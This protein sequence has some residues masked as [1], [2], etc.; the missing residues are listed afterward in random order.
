MNVIIPLCGKGERFARRGYTTQKPFIKVGGKELIRHTLDSL[1]LTADDT[2]YVVINKRLDDC[3]LGGFLK[4][5]YHNVNVLVLDS[6]TRGAAETALRAVERIKNDQPCLLVDGDNFYTINICE[7]LR[8]APTENAVVVFEQLEGPLVFSYVRVEMDRIVEI[9][10]KRKISNYANTGAYYFRSATLLR[11]ACA[12]ALE[13]VTGEPYISHAIGTILG[14]ENWKPIVISRSN[15]YSLGTP[16]Q[17][18]AF[19][20]RTYAFLFDLDGTL[21]H[22]DAAYYKVWETLLA[23]YN[24][25]LTKEIYDTYIF[26]NSDYSVKT[27]LLSSAPISLE[28]LT[29]RKEALFLSHISDITVVKGALEFINSLKAEAHQIAVVT[30]ANRGSAEAILKHIGLKPDTLVIGSECTA[31]KPSHHPYTKAMEMLDTFWAKAFVF[32]DSKNGVTSARNARVSCVVG[33]SNSYLDADVVYPDYRFTISDLLR[34]EKPKVDY[35]ALV[36]SSLKNKYTISN[37]EVSPISLKGG[38]IADVLSVNMRIDSKPVKA[39]LKLMNNNDSPLNKM[40][41]FLDLYGRENYFYESIAP[42]VP[43]DVPKCYG[44]L[45]DAEYKPVGFILEDMRDTAVINRNLSTEPLDVSLAVIDGMAKLHAAFWNKDLGKAFPLLRK[46][47]DSAYNPTWG[48]FMRERVD[49]FLSKWSMLLSKH[50]A[51][52][53]REIVDD[54]ENIQERLGTGHLTLTHGDIKSPNIFY[55]GDTPCFIDWQYI[56]HGKGVQDL[57]FFMIESFSKDRLPLLYPIFINYYY[58]KLQQYGVT[59]YTQ[60]E[61]NYDLKDAMCHFPFFVALW[62]G[63]TPNNDLLD[64]NFPYFY[65][66]R[67]F[68][69]YDMWGV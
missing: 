38:F 4:K 56:A 40:A 36:K 64:V 14:E 30:N 42:F 43:V 21:V 10:E 44:L 2:L 47:N 18:D 49:L 48:T 16:E 54:F 33:I 28:A 63:T 34:I 27:K 55:K 35:A 31:P 17:V 39:V 57:V 23:D 59:D 15:Y 65:I 46:H 12:S 68:A 69:F 9:A 62:F 26:S 29:E 53:V 22:T 45:R 13:K 11:K 8:A 67:L 51:K 25:Y 37:V 60:V 7:Q 20:K 6:E 66:E 3:G 5:Y 19:Q 1:C 32:E 50:H 24:I 41:H 61:Y 52:V 58:A